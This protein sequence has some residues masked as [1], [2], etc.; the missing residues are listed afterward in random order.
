MAISIIEQAVLDCTLA[1]AMGVEICSIPGPRMNIDLDHIYID[2]H[3]PND[4]P[5]HYDYSNKELQALFPPEAYAPWR[6]LD[7]RKDSQSKPTWRKSHFLSLPENLRLKIYKYALTDPSVN[8]F[9]VEVSQVS[10]KPH[11]DHT[12]DPS[13]SSGWKATQTPTQI[14]ATQRNHRNTAINLSILLAN[15]QIYKEALPILYESIRFSLMTAKDTLPIFLSMLSPFARSHIRKLKLQIP[16][17]E[18]EIAT[19]WAIACHQVTKLD[20]T[21]RHIQIEGDFSLLQDD[22]GHREILYPLCK[23]KAPR[24]FVPDTN[25]ELQALLKRA[26][27]LNEQEVLEEHQSMEASVMHHGKAQDDI[28]SPTLALN[29]HHKRFG[30]QEMASVMSE[31]EFVDM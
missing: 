18:R 12:R 19:E 23:I 26:E 11:F 6:W 14:I 31:W 3:G 29:E 28:H 8:E 4:E 30:D 9:V 21:L 24:I 16:G 27:E 17:S 10:F 25:G 2:G 13:N 5:C 22:R 20:G 1:S 7:P 15:R